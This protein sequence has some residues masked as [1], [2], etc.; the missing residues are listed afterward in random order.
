[1][2]AAT[3]ARALIEVTEPLKWAALKEERKRNHI[4]AELS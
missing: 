2:L 4:W 3:S 1:V